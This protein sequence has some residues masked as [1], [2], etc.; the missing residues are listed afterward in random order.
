MGVFVC[1]LIHRGVSLN[2]MNFDIALRERRMF[3]SILHL[4]HVGHIRLMP[5]RGLGG[6]Y[7]AT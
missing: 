1:V 4:V 3:L 5:H 7:Q 2:V 6:G